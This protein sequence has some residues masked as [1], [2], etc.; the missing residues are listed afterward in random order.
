MSLI[1]G[2]KVSALRS[3]ECCPLSVIVVIG[4]V[5]E[6]AAAYKRVDIAFI[7]VVVL[8]ASEAVIILIVDGNVDSSFKLCKFAS[9]KNFY[10]EVDICVT[11]GYAE[12]LEDIVLIEVCTAL[13]VIQPGSP[14]IE[15]CRKGIAY[16]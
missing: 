12:Q 5:T 13:S 7:A 1:V 15:A 8:S 10:L 9:G 6:S 11:Y 3:N 4:Y 14:V 2:I 16:A